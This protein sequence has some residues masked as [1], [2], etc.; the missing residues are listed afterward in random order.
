MAVVCVSGG[1][2]SAVTAATAARDHDL[3]FLHAN[4]G[5]RTE[6]K[7]LACFHALADHY[8]ARERLVVEF[9]VFAAIGG[10]SL[11]D[12]RIPV[13][14]G[15]PEADRIPTSYVPFRNAHLLSAA[16]SW[17]EILGARAI[18]VGAVWEDSSGYP[19]CRPAFYR[20]FEEAIAQGT[21]PET[22]IR[23]ETPVI[24]M[25]KAD[26]VR[27]G[28]AMAVPFEKTWSCYQAEDLACAVCESC[29]LRLRG[30]AEAGVADPLA[31]RIAL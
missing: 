15:E 16:T 6:R 24:R 14:E 29:R 4:Y 23:I 19:D 7:E 25:S 3:A 28:R 20:A 22:A 10:S 27:E 13:R 8:R 9:P 26:I 11:T 21:R 1:M 17:G 12:R 18:F 5:Q 2:D 30:F 31:Y